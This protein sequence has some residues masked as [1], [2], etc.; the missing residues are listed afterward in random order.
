VFEAVPPLVDTEMAQGQ[1]GSK[2]TP[3][4]LVQEVLRGIRRDQYEIQVGR[5]KMLILLNRLI[6]ALV[7]STVMSK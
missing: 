6:P 5:T 4:A 1:T 7:E 3:E 2:I